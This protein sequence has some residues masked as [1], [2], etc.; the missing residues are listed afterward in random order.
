MAQK[1]MSVA[2]ST[3]AKV[4]GPAGTFED[5]LKTYEGST[6]EPDLREFKYYAK[7]T[8]MIRTEEGLSEAR[9][10]PAMVMET[11]AKG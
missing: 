4:T 6:V 2:G 5:V 9:D 10:N 11:P 3:D 7:G 1:R 8:G